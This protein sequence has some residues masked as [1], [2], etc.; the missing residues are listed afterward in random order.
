MR[1]IRVA[2]VCI[3][4]FGSL[5]KAQTNF[6]IQDIHVNPD[7][8]VTITWPAVPQI[9]YHVMFADSPNGVW[10]NFPDGTMMAGSNV[11]SLGYTDT[12]SLAVTQRFYKVGTPRSPVI[13]TL[14]LDRS[15]SMTPGVP[16][17]P[18]VN[19]NTQGGLYL[20]SA[21]TQFINLFDETLDRA[22]LVTFSVSASND[23]PMSAA[24]APFKNNI[25]TRVNNLPWAGGTC[26]IAGLTN[27]LVIQNNAGAPAN[28][29]KVVVFF[30]DGRGNM[31]T[32][33]FAT[34]PAGGITL[35]FGGLDP[36]TI[37]CPASPDPGANF[38]RTNTSEQTQTSVGSVVGCGGTWAGAILGGTNITPTAVWTNAHGVAQFFCGSSITADATNRC[39]LIANQMRAS[40]NYVF[41]VGLTAPGA[42]APPTLTML[43]Q[44]A[45]D[46]AS[47]TFDPTQPVGAA[48]LSEGNDLTNVFQQ[49][50]ADIMLRMGP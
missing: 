33:K 37:G 40:S 2:L 9:P 46:P 45:N 13:M 32:A 30:T 42:L 29:V 3:L 35:N 14:V 8:S 34:T 39:V 1:A 50:A 31:T 36:A 48:F 11:S 25:I 19:N 43:Q 27:A 26:S 38:W 7:S 17:I 24:G 15:G 16:P 5:A 28:A 4:G 41:T 22:A 44:I 6:F 12:N 21:V 20:P 23:V 18:C 49:V 47:P 10:Q